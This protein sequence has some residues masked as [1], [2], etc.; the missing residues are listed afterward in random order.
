MWASGCQHWPVLAQYCQSLF[1]LCISRNPPLVAENE[2][3]SDKTL[4]TLPRA[5][6]C[7]PSFFSLMNYLFCLCSGWRKLYWSSEKFASL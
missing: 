6:L 5:P 4:T 1:G 2:A 7:L 3:A